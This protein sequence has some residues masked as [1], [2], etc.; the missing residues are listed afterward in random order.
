MKIDKSNPASEQVRYGASMRK[1]ILDF[2]KQFADGLAA[3]KNVRLIGDF[4]QLIFCGM[5]G[6]ALPAEILKIL[7][8]FYKWPLAIKIH[9]SYGLPARISPKALVF[10]IS[11]S[12]NT[13]E[14]I[15]SCEEAKKRNLP[16]IGIATGGKLT[17]LCERDKAPLVK[18]PATGIQPRSALGYLFA[19]V[20]KVLSNCNIIENL[21]K[22]ILEMA[23]ALNPK[24]FEE[25]GKKLA[26]KIK[27][28]IPIIYA[29]DKFK[30]L[31]QIW[32]IN[33]NENSK[34][35]AFWNYFPELNHNEMVGYEEIKSQKSKIKSNFHVIILRDKKLDHPRILKRMTLTAKLLKEKGIK[36]DIIDIRDV[37]ILTK[38]FSNYILSQWV[39]YYL[40]LEYGTDPTPVK[41]VEEFKKKLK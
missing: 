35:P 17:E 7:R 28:K 10:A 8:N 3:A 40:A 1:V 15:S 13:E 19:A 24:A 16:V 30:E 12:G 4:N 20:V 32:K 39:S 37:N 23:K 38:I 2:P 25:Q 14:T 36:V 9:K 34:S 22:D 31:A 33:F 6:S 27:G 18:V 5:G 11:Y 21:E 26:Q 29:S 41:M